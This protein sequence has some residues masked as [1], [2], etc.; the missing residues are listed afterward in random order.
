MLCQFSTEWTHTLSAPI[1]NCDEQ[2]SLLVLRWMDS[3][4]MKILV[5]RMNRCG[6]KTDSPCQL[7]PPHSFL[8]LGEREGALLPLRRHDPLTVK[9]Y[10]MAMFMS[11][12]VERLLT[13]ACFWTTWMLISVGLSLLL[14]F[15]HLAINEWM[16]H[17][18]NCYYQVKPVPFNSHELLSQNLPNLRLVGLILE[19]NPM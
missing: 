9:A 7:L 17:S 6:H 2:V 8:K 12:Y 4:Q 15:L 18:A 3:F 16:R 11:C 13:V 10:S 14:S 5:I 19:E 1:E